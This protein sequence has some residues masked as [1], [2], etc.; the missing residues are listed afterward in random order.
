[1]APRWVRAL[2][3]L[4]GVLQRVQERDSLAIMPELEQIDAADRAQRGE[5]AHAPVGAGG[6]AAEMRTSFAT[7]ERA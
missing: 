2:L 7:R 4:R 6:A 5:A 1:M 3:P